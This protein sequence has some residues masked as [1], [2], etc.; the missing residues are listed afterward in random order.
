MHAAWTAA[1]DQR[2]R[3][4]SADVSSEQ[5]PGQKAI[6]ALRNWQPSVRGG[7]PASGNTATELA[8][9]GHHVVCALVA[10][11]GSCAAGTTLGYASAAMPSIEHE[12]WYD[13]RHNTADSRWFADILLLVA[14][15]AALA[16]GFL[17]ERVGN[18]LMLLLSTFGLLGSWLSLLF[19]TSTSAIFV[20]RLMAG[21]FLGAI[22][23][24]AGV[25]VAEICPSERRAFFL[26]FVEVTRSA[27]ILLAYVLGQFFTWEIQAGFCMVPPLVLMCMQ[28]YVLDSP[29][30]LMRRGKKAE[31]L[32][33]LSRLYG[34][35]VP[36]EFRIRS[37]DEMAKTN[38][39]A[40]P[41]KCAKCMALALLVQ[42]LP[43]LSGVRL[44][45]MRGEQVMLSLMAETEPWDAV[46]MLLVAGHVA[47]S[48]M[49]ASLTRIA[50]RRHLLFLSA[51]ITAVC[52]VVLSPLQHIVFSH[53][54][55]EDRPR[56]TD[57]NGIYAVGLLLASYSLGLGH[58]PALLST[59]LLPGRVRCIGAASSW[60]GR[61]S[62]AFLLVHEDA[63]LSAVA[64]SS[65]G[66]VP[67]LILVAGAMLAALVTPETQGRTLLAIEGGVWR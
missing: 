39:N 53:W 50:G 49:F 51:F 56:L 15:P 63:W 5:Q 7:T 33:A 30:W 47:L 65:Q 67:G 13:L 35:D 38:S 22:S 43:E 57:W 61:W 27:G 44:L 60:A 12:T 48:G 37:A 58:V 24:S 1:S 45:L 2:G 3:R 59:E 46:G 9:S 23:S 4:Q 25:H 52:V 40:T 29:Q 36:V 17:L 20:A 8:T 16:A 6:E 66:L 18:R 11:L 41:I 34:L 14:A 28:R 21:V 26:G 32:A 54:T 64:T 62:L 55:V 19:S 10:C 31:A 42:L